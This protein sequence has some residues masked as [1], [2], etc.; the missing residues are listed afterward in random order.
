MTGWGGLD[1]DEAFVN[2]WDPVA[3]TELMLVDGAGELIEFS[4]V[5]PERKEGKAVASFFGGMDVALCGVV[6]RG[7]DDLAMDN[8]F[9]GF[10]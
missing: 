7:L 3:F 2:A 4:F 9:L 5:S 1:E 6:R 10:D 8:G